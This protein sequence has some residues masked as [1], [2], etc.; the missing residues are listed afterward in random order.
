MKSRKAQKFIDELIDQLRLSIF[1]EHDQELVRLK[2]G[3]S[4]KEQLRSAMIHA[5]ELAEEEAEKR[6]WA[7]TEE[8]IKLAMNGISCD[9]LLR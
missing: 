2:I 9:D 6:A 8:L 4:A 7:K 3:D 1:N 5:V